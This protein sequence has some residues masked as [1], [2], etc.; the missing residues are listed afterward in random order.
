M[1]HLAGIS[2]APQTRDLFKVVVSEGKIAGSHV[3]KVAV[4][5]TG[6]FDI[7]TRKTVNNKCYRLFYCNNW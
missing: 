6:I 5:A 4:R 2:A 7:L 1:A 3:G